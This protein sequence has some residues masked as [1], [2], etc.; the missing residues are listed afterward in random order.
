MKGS[1]GTVIGLVGGGIGILTG[2]ILLFLG[3]S[4]QLTLDTLFFEDWSFR[5]LGLLVLAFS[6]VLCIG[7]L[8]ARSKPGAS[9]V[10]LTGGGVI[11]FIIGGGVFVI[12]MILALIS[13][14]VVFFKGRASSGLQQ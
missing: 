12:P 1:L 8:L 7:A 4:Y 10:L 11:G 2:I 6:L 5:I 3:S 9:V 14:A 13:A